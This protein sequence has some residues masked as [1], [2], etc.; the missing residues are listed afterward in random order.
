MIDRRSDLSSPNGA[1]RP[2]GAESKAAILAAAECL[3]A[4]EGFDGASTRDIAAQA[5][6]TL[7]LIAH[8]FGTKENLFI[9]AVERR[10]DAWEARVLASLAAAEAEPDA[11]PRALICAFITPF[12]AC[13]ASGDEG[14]IDYLRLLG[15]GMSV[16][17]HESIHPVL[18]RLSDI[19]NAFRAA[20]CRH[21]AVQDEE[22]LSLASYLL[23]VAL[24][25]VVQDRGLLRARTGGQVAV[26]ELD[27][28]IAF[29][30]DYFYGAFTL[31]GAIVPRLAE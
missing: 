13:L 6:V 12:V 16:Y 28:R 23:E 31:S 26:E 22:A 9:A 27:R 8:H 21:D 15:R 1:R 4:R 3:F 25:Y 18:H 19:P 17:S 10:Y 11:G 29:L 30:T 2:R 24:T 14:W 7:N 5:G 20:L